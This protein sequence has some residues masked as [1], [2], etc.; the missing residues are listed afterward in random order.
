MKLKK[1]LQILAV[2]AVSLVCV[3]GSFGIKGKNMN[4]VVANASSNSALATVT[5]SAYDETLQQNDIE[6]IINDQT[7]SIPQEEI[8]F[9][10]VTLV[11]GD[12]KYEEFEKVF[13]SKWSQSKIGKLV[14]FTVSC[15]NYPEI[16]AKLQSERNVQIK[17]YMPSFL[18]NKS[19]YFVAYGYAPDSYS[20]ITKDNLEIVDNNYVIVTMNLAKDGCYIGLVYDGSWVIVIICIAVFL[21]ILALCIYLKIRKMHREDPEYY[22]ALKREKEQKKAYRKS[23]KESG[24]NA[25][26]KNITNQSKTNQQKAQHGQKKTTAT[27]KQ[28]KRKY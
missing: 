15:P 4:G 1:C 7:I 8:Q 12:E 18:L 16:E 9:N 19:N 27:P 6:I 5:L 17:I 11:N 23:M 14:Y 24:G 13:K 10:Y 21:V 2:F 22:Q 28:V 3:M 25:N 26:T 20:A